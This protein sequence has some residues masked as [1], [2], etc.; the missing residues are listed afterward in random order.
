MS[1]ELHLAPSSY[2]LLLP[3]RSPFYLPPLYSVSLFLTPSLFLS[4]SLC[5]LPGNI[6]MDIAVVPA[7]IV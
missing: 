4:V 5:L 7:A 2:L 3:Y 1:V 6:P